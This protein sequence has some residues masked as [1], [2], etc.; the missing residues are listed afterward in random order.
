[1]PQIDFY[2]NENERARFI[3]YCF[4]QGCNIIP[5]LHYDT[6][7]YIVVANMKQYELHCKECP[8]LFIVSNK[9]SAYPLEL[10]QFEK[11]SKKK[12]FIRQRHGG[13]TIDFYSPVLGELENNI[14]GPGYIGIYPFYYH[15][16]EKYIPN[17]NFI[18]H[19]KL[20]VSY[21]KESSQKV[22]LKQRTFWVGK[23]T[24][25]RAKRGA[26]QLLPVSNTDILSCLSS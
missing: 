23:H 3:D 14:V 10:E 21:I 9:F 25:E 18:D 6:E 24:I 22:K 1:M 2:L 8:L 5:D 15:E 20:F 13:P 7:K 19:Y 16:N 26:V 4:K 17:K 11:E 12:Y